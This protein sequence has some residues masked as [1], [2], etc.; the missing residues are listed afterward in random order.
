[1]AHGI[2]RS[3]A[4]TGT[5]LAPA[6]VSIYASADLDNGNVVA[7]GGYK[8]GE[9]EIH[10]MS[11]PTASSALK[12]LAVIG[13][14][15]VDKRNNN[16]ALEDFYNKTGSTCRGYMLRSGDIFSVTAEAFELAKSGDT[17]I[18]PTVGTTIFEAQAGVKMLAV[19]TAT[20]GSTKIGELVR[21]ETEGGKTWYVIKVA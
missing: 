18:T 2:F 11:T 17:A 20:S 19:N 21:I 4:M 10:T 14:E 12:D 16:A 7:V 3:D 8:T 6:L 15:E 1:M 13:S 5:L 9:R